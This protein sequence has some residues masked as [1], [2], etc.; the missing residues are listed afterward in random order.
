MLVLVAIAVRT[1]DLHL[2][3]QLLQCQLAPTQAKTELFE[4]L[5]G[6]PPAQERRL[7]H[8]RMDRF[9]IEVGPRLVSSVHALSP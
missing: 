6:L 2:T 8:A 7:E 5:H 4:S 1:E 3:A 9:S